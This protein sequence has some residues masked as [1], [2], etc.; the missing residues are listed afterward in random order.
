MIS[1]GSGNFGYICDVK[2]LK[3]IIMDVDVFELSDKILAE[4]LKSPNSGHSIESLSRVLGCD[5][6]DMRNSFAVLV[7]RKCAYVSTDGLHV[8]NEGGDFY[9]SGGFREQ[10]RREKLA[11]Q[12]IEASIKA[13][14]TSRWV[15]ISALIVA[16]IT[17]VSLVVQIILFLCVK[18]I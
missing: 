16:S 11:T 14:A 13:Y 1:C 2:P 3:S 10:V 7:S 6:R 8:T 18:V 17:C 9:M 5:E 15:S 12:N 4:L